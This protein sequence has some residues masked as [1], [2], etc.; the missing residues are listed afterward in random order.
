MAKGRGHRCPRPATSTAHKETP[1]LMPVLVSVKNLVT[2]L[3]TPVT[4]EHPTKT[5]RRRLDFAH[6]GTPPALE[7]TRELS[8]S[9][10]STTLP[11]LVSA[12]W[13]LHSLWFRGL[14]AKC[15]PFFIAG[16]P[17]PSPLG[18]FSRPRRPSDQT[19]SRTV[20]RLAQLEWALGTLVL[21]AAQASASPG[22]VRPSLRVQAFPLH[23][24]SAAPS[25]SSS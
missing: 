9:W 5:R 14:H 13:A 21:R 23:L 15:S 16:S 6:N 7:S 24:L 3:D 18:Q 8:L 12:E 10:E 19:V 17:K 4:A 1:R 22:Q 11:L 2:A 20:A 25:P